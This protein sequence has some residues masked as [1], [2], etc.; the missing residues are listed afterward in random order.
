MLHVGDVAH[1]EFLVAVLLSQNLKFFELKN[2]NL[3]D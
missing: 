3:Y 1:V 2:P